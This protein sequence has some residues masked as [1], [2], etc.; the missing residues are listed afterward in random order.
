[1]PSGHVCP[2]ARLFFYVGFPACRRASD[3]ERGQS[4]A[5]LG[6]ASLGSLSSCHVC[7]NLA[8]AQVLKNV[9]VDDISWQA[10]AAFQARGFETP[11]FL[12]HRLNAFSN[13]RFPTTCISSLHAVSSSCPWTPTGQ[14]GPDQTSKKFIL[15]G[16]TLLAC[17]FFC[18][19][20]P[21]CSSRTWPGAASAANAQFLSS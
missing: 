4:H 2:L 15:L 7:A 8:P 3:H 11:S 13:A 6:R 19:Q 18:F 1:M 17:F 14:D 21:C 20:G 5:I 10:Q 9:L 16:V 12:Q